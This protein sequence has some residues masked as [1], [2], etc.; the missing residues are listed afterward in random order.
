MEIDLLYCDIIVQRW[1]QFTGKKCDREEAT[2]CSGPV[3]NQPTAS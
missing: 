3:D 1:E 2:A